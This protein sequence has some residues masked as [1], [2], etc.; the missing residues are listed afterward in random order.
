[1]TLTHVRAVDLKSLMVGLEGMP[2][3]VDQL[4][5][6]L[7]DTFLVPTPQHLALLLESILRIAD[8]VPWFASAV[9]TADFQSLAAAASAEVKRV[10]GR[11]DRLSGA[12]SLSGGYLLSRSIVGKEPAPARG[13]EALRAALLICALKWH[14]EGRPR[15][16]ALGDLGAA[17]RAITERGPQGDAG[18]PVTQHL[19]ELGAA[20]T[21]DDFLQAA[22][23][24]M[25]CGI[26]RL[27]NA[28]ARH[29]KPALQEILAAIPPS[30]IEPTVPEPGPDV[31]TGEDED[32]D[33]LAAMIRAVVAGGGPA[34]PILEPGEPL[35]EGASTTF[36]VPLPRNNGGKDA[37]KVANYLAQQAIWGS[38]YLLLTN[39]SDVLPLAEFR[40]VVRTVLEELAQ[41]GLAPELRCGLLGLLLQ[42]LTGR[43]PRTLPSIQTQA[44]S[45]ERRLGA[46]GLS[47]S[48]GFMELDVFWRLRP[49]DDKG[50][51]GFFE[52]K[53]EFLTCFDPVATHFRLPLPPQVV[54]ALKEHS[55]VVDELRNLDVA[56]LE[57]LLRGALRHVAERT[58]FPL[59]LGQVRRSF[60]VHFYETTR[61]VALTQLVSADTL[62]QA[63]ASLHYYA[64]RKADIAKAYWGFLGSLLEIHLPLPAAF[65]DAQRVGAASLLAGAHARRMASTSGG[66]LNRGIDRLIR[67]GA[68]QEVHTAMVRHVVSM[69]LVVAGHRP[70]DALFELRLSDIHL[71]KTGGMALFRDKVHDPAHNPRFA[72][73]AP[74]LVSQVWA[75]LGHLNGLAELQPAFA[76]H[77][78]RVMAGREPL[79]FGI[80]D[81][82][83][84][85]PLNISDWRKSLPEEW[86]GLPLNWGRT[87]L[88][89]R[90]VEG[91]LPPELAALQL[92]H[93]ESVGYPFS[94]A[95]PSVPQAAMSVIAPH[96]EAMAR[97]LGW[98]VRAGIPTQT[99]RVKL[100]LPQL[101]HWKPIITRHEAEWREQVREWRQWQ[102]ARIAEVRGRAEADVLSHPLIVSRG[103]A[104]S[105]SDPRYT[106]RVE[107]LELNEA[108]ALRDVLYEDAG[109]D[110]AL[111]IARS[112]ALRHIVRRVNKR[113]GIAGKDPGVLGVFRRPVDNAFIPGMMAAVR[114]VDAL[115]QHAASLGSAS[116]GDWKDFDRACARVAY[117]LAVFGFMEHP[118]QIEG[119]MRHREAYVGPAGLSDTILVPWSERSGDVVALRNL[120]AV[121]VARLAKRYPGQPVPDRNTLGASLRE[122]LPEWALQEAAHG[123]RD[124]LA[125]LCECV[126][127][128][129]RFELSPA[130]RFALDPVHGST[131]ASIN[132]QLA[133]VDGDPVGTIVRGEPENEEEVGALDSAGL[134]DPG[135]GSARTQYKT[136]CAVL[137]S[138]GH[139]LR[140]PSTGVE[141]PAS[142]LFASGTRQKVIAEVD[143]LVAERR[144]EKVLRPIVRL[145]ALWVRQMLVEGT[146]LKPEPADKTVHTYLTRIGGALVEL[147]GNSSLIGFDEIDLEEIYLAAI[148]AGKSNQGQAASAIL[149]FHRCCQRHVDMPDVDFVEVRSYLRA[150]LR[151]ADAQMI[152][153]QERVA[154]LEQ[155]QAASECGASS[156]LEEVRVLRQAAAALPLF[157]WGGARRSEVL[158]LRQRDVWETDR[159]VAILVRRNRSRKL[160]TRA[161]RRTVR[162]DGDRQAGISQS[163]RWM[164]MD[165]ERAPGWS[166]SLAYVFS[167]E[168]APGSAEGRHGI[169]HACLGAISSVTRRRRERIHRFRHLVATERVLPLFLSGQDGK[170]M[171]ARVPH[172]EG[173]EG[174]CIAMPRDLMERI[175]GIGHVDW[176]TTFRCYLHFPWLLRSLQ[177]QAIAEA[178]MGRRELA[179][180]SGVT[181]NAIDRVAQTAKDDRNLASAWIDHVR[182][183][184]IV[185]KAEHDPDRPVSIGERSWSARELDHLFKRA[186][187]MGLEKAA[188]VMGAN[189][190]D[191]AA[192]RC[193]LRVVELRMGRRLFR[194]HVAERDE[195]GPLRQIKRIQGESLDAV[196]AWFDSLAP[197]ARA[198][199]TQVIDRL[200]EVMSPFA[201]VG[202]EGRRDDLLWLLSELEQLLPESIQMNVN[203]LGSGGWALTASRIAGDTAAKENDATGFLRRAVATIWL[204]H[205]PASDNPDSA[206]VQQ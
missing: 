76:A 52:P 173:L 65:N 19:P 182:R 189:A 23:V 7:V 146:P 148:R 37:R 124:P 75:Y 119:V 203:S 179:F 167:P 30:V 32:D 54:A 1:M 84:V 92:G 39:H 197:D 49:T 80:S 162:F 98:R 139:A 50:R 195:P 204:A 45:V 200:V 94:N 62:G 178:H 17:I 104:G 150:S 177:D 159:H 15:R 188:T 193:R 25:S 151:V 116:P 96:L 120:A 86:Q 31:A 131:C 114:Q 155:A 161:A 153:P 185:P 99:P 14:M 206:P 42:A 93:L 164:R 95:S 87:W 88:R 191:V 190:A 126:G 6:G 184:R 38:N 187:R 9:P 127:V 180:A 22:D 101:L 156:S 129:N 51:T 199:A 149:E 73:L 72:A 89:T 128:A 183:T 90:G 166:R 24:L 79:L 100:P 21:L 134:R 110:M 198:A 64:P 28:W 160:K 11:V 117:V 147:I 18:A 105:Y 138:M 57:S 81:Q 113:L 26:E 68:W 4:L 56:K 71:G 108:E 67:Q 46:C 112:R 140:L 170:W 82:A 102:M 12:S 201:Q 136:L 60:S 175:V 121:A 115:R 132:E 27:E 165:G 59:I 142:Q 8:G 78:N 13:P 3:Q 123:V 43:T 186:D 103:I 74:C 40:R 135:T 194:R 36:L 44:P 169:A 205:R 63:E 157:A 133:F 143:A 5:R 69:F 97:D 107:P 35:D 91:G 41:P 47:L 61:D 122:F 144:P 176:R 109:D 196:L 2:T 55:S 16:S 152:L 158:G 106:G 85:L 181:A 118:D 10:H 20:Q 53:P 154:I 145:L 172:A 58:G 77:V 66:L 83:S 29:F 130:A 137:P 34:P 174:L 192:I 168:S 171:H 33:V 70:V 141:V 163:V 48:G 125:L 111:G 202:V